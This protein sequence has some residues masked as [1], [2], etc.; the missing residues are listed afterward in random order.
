MEGLLRRMRDKI[1]HGKKYLCGLSGNDVTVKIESVNT[2]RE[3]TRG[4]LY[5]ITILSS[6]PVQRKIVIL[7]YV[8]I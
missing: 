7:L 6:A 4:S 2:K 8:L 1:M 3:P 5:L